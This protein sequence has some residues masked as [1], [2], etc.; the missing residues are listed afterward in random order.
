M[1]TEQFW[2]AFMLGALAMIW[3]A[4]FGMAARHSGAHGEYWPF[5]VLALF[6]VPFAALVGAC[7]SMA[8]P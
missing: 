5:G 8:L 1:M 2:G 3:L 4:C 7:L 6:T